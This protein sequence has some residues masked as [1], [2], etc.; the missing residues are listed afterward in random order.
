MNVFVETNYVLELALEQEE[1]SIC[2][3]LLK[4]GRTNAIRLLLPAYSLIEPHETLT[5][6][7]L[8][9]DAL[10][11][12]VEAELTQMG[13]SSYLAERVG[14]SREL[15]QLLTDSAEFETEHI[16]KAKERIWSVAEVL[17]LNHEVLRNAAH[18]REKFEFS[19]QDAVVYASIRARL[20][21]DHGSTSC[22]VSRN[23]AD[24]ET[25]RVRRDLATFN[26]KYF[27]SFEIALQYIEHTLKLH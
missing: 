8:D 1:S 27:A 21:V 9:R 23:P 17:P 26:C 4:Y 25:R 15:V 12:R 11:T 19:P 3:K 18:Y 16:E 22:F 10:R 20:A 13:R 6:R 2:E 5:R 7:R 14:A 24:F